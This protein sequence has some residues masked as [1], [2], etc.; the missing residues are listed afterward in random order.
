MV[1]NSWASFC[2]HTILFLMKRRP[3][4][5][6]GTEVQPL[7]IQVPSSA[8]DRFSALCLYYN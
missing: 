7:L 4:E 5:N 3:K 6:Q 1:P 8:G 2:I